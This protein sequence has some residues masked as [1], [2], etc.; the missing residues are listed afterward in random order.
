MSGD[1]DD[2]LERVE[3]ELRVWMGMQRLDMPIAIVEAFDRSK[4]VSSRSH[5]PGTAT[6]DR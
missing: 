1:V 4:R 2:D 3:Q 5:R 6:R